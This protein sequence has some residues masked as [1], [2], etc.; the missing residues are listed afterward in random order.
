MKCAMALA[1]LLTACASVPV[2]PMPLEGDW[3]GT[4]LGLHLTRTGGTLDYDCAHGTIGPVLLG[5]G[6]QFMAQ[7][8][9]TPEH[10]GPARE[11]EVLPALHVRY[12]GIV[13]NDRIMLRGKVE[14]GV[15]L[16]PFELKRGA[17]PQIFRCL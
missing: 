3:G 5:E 4:H 12:D 7:G 11:G 9:H 6:G 13:R 15:L 14:T 2:H 17:E 8:T 10:G 1:A 16:G